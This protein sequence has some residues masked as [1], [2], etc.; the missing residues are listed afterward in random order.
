MF[1][2]QEKL[3]VSVSESKKYSIDLCLDFIDHSKD[4]YIP[5]IDRLQEN[6]SFEIK[7]DSHGCFHHSQEK[8][9]IRRLQNEFSIT[10]GE[11]TKTLTQ[12]D[13]EA[14]RKFE[15]EL[16]YMKDAGCTTADTYVVTYNKESKKITDGSCSWKGYQ[17]LRKQLF[18]ND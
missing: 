3:N 8:I 11:E 18:G 4:N 15:I 12:S 6:E 13:I 17:Y 5:V 16:N 2:K 1:G 10:W 9:T 7:M 14:V